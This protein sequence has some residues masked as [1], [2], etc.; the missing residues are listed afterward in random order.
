MVA[1]EH[2]F[3]LRTVPIV[4]LCAG[5]QGDLDTERKTLLLVGYLNLALCHL[6]LQD[7]VEARDQCNKALKLDPSSEKGLFRRLVLLQV[8]LY[9]R[10]CSRWY[11]FLLHTN[12][13]RN[14]S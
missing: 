5:F 6:K 7:H 12:F 1:F 14:Y 8:T 9:Q 2:V 11:F 3:S 13:N 4:I 10:F